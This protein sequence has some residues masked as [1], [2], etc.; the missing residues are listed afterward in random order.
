MEEENII[1][2]EAK[3]F[4][5]RYL[6]N[7]SKKN[8]IDQF[9]EIRSRLV[10][11]YSP[12]YKAIFLD[13]IELN[14]SDDLKKHRDQA[15]GGKASSICEKEKRIEKLL[16]YLKQ[17][18]E[19]LPIVARQKYFPLEKNKRNKVFIS[20]SRLDKEVL[21]DIQ[22]HFKPFLN[23]INYWDDSMIT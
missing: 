8:A 20:Y 10:D 4:F 12:E 7:S 17:E 5:K 3:E 13:E 6:F 2:L 21:S 19:T 22:R 18:L 23:K 11:F 15:H 16:F 9:R 1:R 14:I